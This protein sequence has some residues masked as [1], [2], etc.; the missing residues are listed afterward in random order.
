M[1][2]WD[3]GQIAKELAIGPIVFGVNGQI[4]KRLA[5]GLVIWG[6]GGQLPRPGN[7]QT[8]RKG[9]ITSHTTG[10]GKKIFTC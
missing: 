7:W 1:E 2:F 10:G 6:I 3:N 9:S 5:I 4:A 8:M